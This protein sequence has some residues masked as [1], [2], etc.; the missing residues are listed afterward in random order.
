MEPVKTAVPLLL[1][2]LT[3][4]LI[5]NFLSSSQFASTPP[6]TITDQWQMRI[7]PLFHLQPLS[8]MVHFPSSLFITRTKNH[9]QHPLLCAFPP[10]YNPR[11]PENVTGIVHLRAFPPPYNPR[12]PENVTGIVHLHAWLYNPYKKSLPAPPV[13]CLLVARECSRHC[14]LACLAVYSTLAPVAGV[15]GFNSHHHWI[16]FL[17]LTLF[18]KIRRW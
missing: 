13:V 1:Q 6:T 4:Q 7:V 11:S 14:P 3:G 12:S 17:L 18:L 5:P 8:R 15:R 9:F 16:I 10:P 2:S